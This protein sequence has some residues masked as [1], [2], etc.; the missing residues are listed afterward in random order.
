[1]PK[2]LKSLMV[3]DGAMIIFHSFEVEKTP[4]S[5]PQGKTMLQC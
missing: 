4:T 3:L 1:M 2:S 5:L